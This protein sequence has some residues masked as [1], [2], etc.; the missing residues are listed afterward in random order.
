MPTYCGV[1]V[2]TR[3]ALGDDGVDGYDT[4]MH[5]ERP[6][7][8]YTFG[9]MGAW[10]RLS[11]WYGPASPSLGATRVST[12]TPQYVGTAPLLRWPMGS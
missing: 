4:L 11:A 1:P 10:S 9:L 2:D 8:S 5:R 3:M 12:D 6:R 7:A